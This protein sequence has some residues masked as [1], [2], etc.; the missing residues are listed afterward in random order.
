MS[1]PSLLPS[2]VRE[3]LVADHARLRRLLAELEDLAERVATDRQVA[4]QLH[5]VATQF[6][7]ALE[8]HNQAEERVLEGLLVAADPSE[9][10]RARQM[11]LE[12][13]AEHASILAAF[14]ASD[15][16]ALARAIP[17]LAAELREH[18]DREEKT[19]LAPEAWRG[20]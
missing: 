9:P 7:R 14:Q 18:I 17:L 12:H 2:Q 8:T 13:V 3:A 4:S 16:A 19:V 10:G 15:T 5:A 1:Q 11:M 20:R 6:R